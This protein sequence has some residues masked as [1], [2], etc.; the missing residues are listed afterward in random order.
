MAG[1]KNKSGKALYADW[2]WDNGMADPGWRVWKVGLENGPPALNV[3]LGGGSLGAVF[4]T[5][6]VQLS[7]DPAQLLAWQL[8]FDFGRDADKI[9]AMGGAFE[10]SAWSDVGM[11]SSDLSAFKAHGGKL[12]AP[13][14]V[15]DPVF[16]V[17]DTIGWWKEVD[18]RNKGHAADFARVFP[19]PGMNHCGGGPATD[20][21]DSLTALE[22]WVLK[23]TAPDAIAAVAGA[24]TPWPGRS[25]PLCAYP[26]VARYSGKGDINKAE[27]FS[28]KR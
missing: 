3:V 12:V 20:Q 21:F 8:A 4:T 7:P 14:G 26:K 6:P 19:V 11:R 23:G 27:N 18:R 16:S 22:N 5:P 15:S 28:C 17:L 25:R 13:H 10:T 1:P 9:Y 2:A 24:E